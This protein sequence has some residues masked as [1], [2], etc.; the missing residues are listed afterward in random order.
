MS[1]YFKRPFAIHPAPKT[2]RKFN[3]LTRLC[4]AEIE[5]SSHSL[6]THSHGDDDDDDDVDCNCGDCRESRGESY[7][8]TSWPSSAMSVFTKWGISCV[9]DGSLP[10]GGFELPLAPASG[11]LWIDQCSDVA[12]VLRGVN[13][14]VSNACGLHIHADARDFRWADMRRL[15]AL[16]AHLE[17]TLYNMVPARRREGSYSKPCA[18]LYRRMAAGKTPR[19]KLSASVRTTLYGAGETASERAKT[20]SGFRA[21]LTDTFRRDFYY[22]NGERDPRTGKA[23]KREAYITDRF[24]KL[25]QRDGHDWQ[26]TKCD[27]YNSARYYACNL[28]SWLYRGTVELRLPP[29]T[30]VGAKIANWGMLW[31]GI[32]EFAYTTPDTRLDHIIATT[33]GR[34]A[35]LLTAANATVSTFINERLST[36][37]RS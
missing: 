10:D 37:D 13:A 11:D 16:Y 14:S 24:R 32:V 27:K 12:R 4:A 3:P 34:D 29:G 5:V 36:W 7:R 21:R 8:G 28:H 15:M 20:D 31:A 22:I 25:P 1:L 2:A 17:D 18:D 23:W 6:D 26:H 30:V 35:L 9:S 33:S 19:V